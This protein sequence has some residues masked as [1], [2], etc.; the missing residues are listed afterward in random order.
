MSA[1]QISDL[2]LD[3]LLGQVPAPREPGADLADRIAARALR[4]P[5]E[6]A[7]RFSFIAGPRPRTRA[8]VWTAVVAAN[9]M[10][11]AAAATSWDG[12]RFDL[13]RLTDLPRRVA[14]AVHIRHN[15]S[16]KAPVAQRKA[17]PT[18][19]VAPPVRAASTKIEASRA[20]PSN[21]LPTRVVMPPTHVRQRWAIRPIEQPHV[22]AREN[23]SAQ[24]VVRYHPF[25]HRVAVPP[26]R[27][28]GVRPN[29]RL[30]KPVSVAPERSQ[31]RLPDPSSR[32]ERLEQRPTTREQ[33]APEAVVLAPPPERV[34]EHRYATAGGE[35]W[36]NEKYRR[37]LERWRNQLHQRAHPRERGARFRRRF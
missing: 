20:E 4:T 13:Q 1:A 3:Q 34:G 33:V 27:I 32:Q 6:R 36:R 15:H 28:A 12:Q 16:E 5:Q 7:S 14:A 24:R 17:L 26:H 18:A 21:A 9:L 11:A 37:R 29:G 22:I 35:A 31:F 30:E 25:Q 8:R 2:E 19:R 10:A 23:A